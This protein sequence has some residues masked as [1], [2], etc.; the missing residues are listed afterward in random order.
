MDLE[1]HIQRSIDVDGYRHNVKDFVKV[2][3]MKVLLK[4][5]SFILFL[6]W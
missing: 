4:T 1:G 6:S 2:H 3:N 5:L